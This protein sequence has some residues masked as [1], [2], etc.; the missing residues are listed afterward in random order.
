[1]AKKIMDKWLN[2]DERARKH[3]VMYDDLAEWIMEVYDKE[4]ATWGSM[5]IVITPM[6]YPQY[7]KVI[8]G[9][10]VGLIIEE[11]VIDSDFINHVLHVLGSYEYSVIRGSYGLILKVKT[12]LLN[13]ARTTMRMCGMWTPK[14]ERENEQ[15]S[16]K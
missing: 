8:E 5:N 16:E 11:G 13:N 3:K 4:I 10:S 15:K 2:S 1:M 14:W 6:F 7:P 9:A 12:K